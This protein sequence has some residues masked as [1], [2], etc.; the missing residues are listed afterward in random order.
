M[1]LATCLAPVEVPESLGSTSV[2]YTRAGWEW[3][4]RT[5]IRVVYP[6]PTL[7][8]CAG[9]VTVLEGPEERICVAN[10]PDDISQYFRGPNDVRDAVDWLRRRPR[11]VIVDSFTG[12]W[13]SGY[14][15]NSTLAMTADPSAARWWWDGDKAHTEAVQFSKR[16]NREG[17]PLYAMLRSVLAP[18]EVT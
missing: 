4:K 13:Y 8:G 5:R 9:V 16:V 3:Y 2:K 6:A 12:L 15:R 18:R 10:T 1:T 14:G 11:Y 17:E 7:T